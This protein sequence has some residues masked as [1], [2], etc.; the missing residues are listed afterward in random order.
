MSKERKT[1]V[2]LDALKRVTRTAMEKHGK[3]P[4][5]SEVSRLDAAY[6]KQVAEA[7]KRRS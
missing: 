5:G 4:A 3:I 7:K 1:P 2:T 6:Q